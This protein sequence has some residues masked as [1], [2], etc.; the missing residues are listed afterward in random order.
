ME[1]LYQHYLNHRHVTTDSRAITSGCMFFALKGESFNGNEFALKALE[2]GASLAVVDDENLKNIQGCYLVDNVLTALQSLAKR[3]RQSLQFPVIGITGTNGKTTTK[4]LIRSVLSQKYK[5]S[6]TVGNLNNHIGVPL[7][8]L[9]I[10]LDT[11]LAIIEMG[12]NHPG[13]IDFLCQIANP[14]YGIITN[15]GKAHLEGFGSLAGVFSTKTEMYRFILERNGHLFVNADYTDL[16]A[17]A[18]NEPLVYASKAAGVPFF[19]TVVSADPMLVFR[20]QCENSEP[21]MVNTQLAGAYNLENALAAMRIGAHFNISLEQCKKGIEEYSP[22]NKRS[23]W[24][25]TEHNKVL[26]DAY[27][28]NPT[29]MK[30][31]IL[32]FIGIKADKK[33]LI[34]GDML[35]LGLDSAQEHADI[36]DLLEQHRTGVVIL[37][38][39][40]FVKAASGKSYTCFQSASSL[41]EFLSTHPIENSYIF[42]KASRGIQ[43]EKILPHL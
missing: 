16:L 33:V 4:E 7:T 26:L 38:G 19:G 9:S 28:A 2:Q 27:N 6:A 1:E 39:K 29:S 14:D 13:E 32:N 12:A 20:V 30:H 15:V 41:V 22:S 40:E 3:H 24:I 5:V 37:V 18:G 31:A 23:Q 8:L 25:Q 17:V 11:E 21:M 43:L 10:P 34:L 42:I 35:E 36:L